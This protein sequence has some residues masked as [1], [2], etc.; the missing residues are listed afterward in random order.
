MCMV[1]DDT[2]LYTGYTKTSP[3]DYISGSQT[4]LRGTLVLREAHS[5]VPR[6][7]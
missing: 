3:V 1:A 2:M 7:N 5:S 6:E 4:V